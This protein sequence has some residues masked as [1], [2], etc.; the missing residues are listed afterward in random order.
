MQLYF[1]KVKCNYIHTA[2]KHKG[3]IFVKFK[4]Y[5]YK[6]ELF[7]FGGSALT[8]SLCQQYVKHMAPVQESTKKR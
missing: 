4:D 2:I 8:G 7:P 6:L 1:S 5:K 3:R